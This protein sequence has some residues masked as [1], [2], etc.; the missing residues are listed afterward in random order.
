VRAVL[1]RWRD[2]GN[3]RAEGASLVLPPPLHVGV[4]YGITDVA[5]AAVDGQNVTVSVG[6]VRGGKNDGADR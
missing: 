5:A 2:G 1:E 6:I 4:I 3:A